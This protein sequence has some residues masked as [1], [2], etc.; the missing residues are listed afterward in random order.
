MSFLP[1][2]WVLAQMTPLPGRPPYVPAVLCA[3]TVPQAA[4][5]TV[6]RAL[7][8]D[9]ACFPLLSWA[10][11]KGKDCAWFLFVAAAVPQTGSGTAG[12]FTN[13]C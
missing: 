5:A 11:L 1:V 4:S 7:S 8:A 2:L 9:M 12:V 6:V 3:P 10:L 13:V